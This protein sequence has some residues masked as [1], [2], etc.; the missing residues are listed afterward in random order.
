MMKQIAYAVMHQLLHHPDTGQHGPTLQSW[1]DSAR[2][3]V[4]MTQLDGQVLIEVPKT[5]DPKQV[6]KFLV[7]N[8][9]FAYRVEAE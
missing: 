1:T 5:K 4:R 6:V 2:K 7:D 9:N 8:S 3:G